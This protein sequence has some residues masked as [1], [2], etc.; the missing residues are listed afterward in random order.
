MFKRK[1]KSPIQALQDEIDKLVKEHTQLSQRRAEI[2]S[3]LSN[4]RGLIHSFLRNIGIE[5]APLT[6][7]VDDN[8][9]LR[10]VTKEELY[11]MNAIRQA[12]D[13]SQTW[14]PDEDS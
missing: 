2:E 5:M 7:G 6:T 9:Q 8:S 12:A 10:N 11:A 13:G 14:P 1:D 4:A 3:E